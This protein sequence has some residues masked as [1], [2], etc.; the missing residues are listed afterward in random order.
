M[1]RQITRIHSFALVLFVLSVLFHGCSFG[2]VI[3]SGEVL[4]A[5]GKEFVRTGEL[6]N[7]LHSLGKVSDE[8]YRV[9]ASFARRFKIIYKP[10]VNSWLA[11][12]TVKDKQEAADA[13]RVIRAELIAFALAIDERKK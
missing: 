4:D 12:A 5:T 8:D 1:Q 13:L 3:M 7:Q 9:W 10:V 11:A 2:N 6:F